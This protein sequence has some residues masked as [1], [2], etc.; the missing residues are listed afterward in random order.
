MK[1]FKIKNRN[2]E[3]EILAES[4]DDCPYY[5]GKPER[6]VPISADYDPDDVIEEFDHVVSP[7]VDEVEN[8]AGEV[9]QEAIPAVTVK[10]VK[11]KAEYTVEIIDITAQAEQEK[12][13]AEALAYL[14]STDWMVIR[15]M[16]SGLPCPA[17]VKTA[18]AAARAK[19][20]R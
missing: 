19:I 4:L 2:G 13:N 20:V 6:V 12:I 14:A 1:K 9:V 3:F 17:D 10:M 11:L 18:R 5:L 8:E 15:E 7:A 16:D